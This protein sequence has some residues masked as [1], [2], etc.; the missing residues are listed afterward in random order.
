MKVG[1]IA[2]VHLDTNQE[3]PVLD[4]LCDVLNKEQCTGLIIAG[5]ITDTAY[6]TL[7]SLEQIR[8]KLDQPLLFVPGNHD[9]WDPEKKFKNT[10][11]IY[12]EYKQQEGCLC[13]KTVHLEKDKIVTG[14]IGWY[15]YSFGAPHYTKEEFAK[16]TQAGRV[17]QDS[18]F[19][20]W[21]EDDQVVCQEMLQEMEHVFKENHGKNITAV[22]HMISIPECSVIPPE[23]NWDYFNAFLGS[24]CYGKAYEAYGVSCG[25]MGHVHYRKQVKKGNVD[26]RCACLGYHTEWTTKDV[27]TE[28]RDSLQ[29][30]E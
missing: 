19:V 28:I 29:F 2:D 18:R 26:Y 17:W 16:K 25:I 13:G 4:V 10:W 20:H 30:L 27:E 9:L 15:D 8:K 3:Y 22:T 14:S 7:E 12:E 5:D 6:T 1:I 24:A 23:K 21:E 11:Q